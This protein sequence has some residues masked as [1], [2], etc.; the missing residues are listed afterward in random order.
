MAQA[1]VRVHPDFRGLPTASSPG[2]RPATAPVLSSRPPTLTWKPPSTQSP[3]TQAW[4]YLPWGDVLRLLRG[5]YSFVLRSYG[6][7]RRSRLLSP[8]SVL[9]LVP[10]VL[11]GCYQPLLPPASSRLYLCKSF[12]RCL[13][14]CPDGS[15]R[16]L[17]PVSSSMSSAFPK[18]LMGRL[19]VGSANATFP[20]ASCRG[21]RHSFMFRPLSLLASQIAPTAASFPTGQP[22]LLH[23]GISCFV[24]SARSGYAIRPIQ[25][26]DGEG[27]CTLPDLQPCRLLQCLTSLADVMTHYALC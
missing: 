17:L 26:I 4:C 5:H 16:V 19:P 21:C 8:P 1:L 22:R 10:G 14:P 27:T 24:A 15:H 2:Q 18:T 11:A 7:M 25:V 9:H 6:L 12:P 13:A 20:R 23:P 3:F